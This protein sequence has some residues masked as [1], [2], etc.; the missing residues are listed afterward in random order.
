MGHAFDL[1]GGINTK[2]GANDYIH[3][4]LGHAAAFRFGLDAHTRITQTDQTKAMYSGKNTQ[5]QQL[6]CAG[7]ELWD[8]PHPTPPPPSGTLQSLML[9]VQRG[10]ER[11]EGSAMQTHAH[12]FCT[13]PC[14]R[15]FTIT[16]TRG[17]EGGGHKRTCSRGAE[18]HFLCCQVH[19]A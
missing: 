9:N 8:H 15:R 11:D 2:L 16:T 13:G 17:R 1:C 5:S 14:G 10:K 7:W 12:R 18:N 6:V 19:L 4:S 3:Q